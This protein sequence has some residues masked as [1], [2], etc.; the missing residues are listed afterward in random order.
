MPATNGER[1]NNTFADQTAIVTGGGSGIGAA[2]ARALAARGTRVVI[3]DVDEAA[4][5][6]VADAIIAGGGL[7]NVAVVD[8]REAAAVADLVSQTAAEHGG[9]GLMCN[10][11]GIAIGGLVEELTLDH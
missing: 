3:A 9:L 6:T 7:A 10:N 4:A 11:A 2:I 8:V 1:E 5:K